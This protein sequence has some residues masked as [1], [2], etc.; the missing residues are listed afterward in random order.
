MSYIF[1][2]VPAIYFV[3]FF[4][5]SSCICQIDPRF[6]QELIVDEVCN[7]LNS[8]LAK[9]SIDKVFKS[10]PKVNS[11]DDFCKNTKTDYT[12]YSLCINEKVNK[13]LFT[14]NKL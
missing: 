3:L 6:A 5:P 13:C 7:D 8:S 14:L 9:H 1:K 4:N 11:D 12:K 2:L 10:H